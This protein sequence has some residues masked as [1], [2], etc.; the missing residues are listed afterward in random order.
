M[1]EQSRRINKIEAVSNVLLLTMIRQKLE[2]NVKRRLIL[3]VN[4]NENA[5]LHKRSRN[6][7]QSQLNYDNSLTITH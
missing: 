2:E 7:N 6:Q 4:T 3:P 1:T 5:E